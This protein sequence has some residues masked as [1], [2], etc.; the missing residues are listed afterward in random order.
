MG[1]VE[2]W[3]MFFES[4][5]SDI[6]SLIEH[7]IDVAACDC[8]QE[9]VKRR[10]K[11][12]EMVYASR[13]SA[14]DE[15]D[16]IHKKVNDI[17]ERINSY[18][19]ITVPVPKECEIVKEV[20]NIKHI[21]SNQDESENQLGDSLR[22]MESMALSIEI[23]KETMIGRNVK[24]LQKHKSKP[25]SSMAKKLVRRWREVADEWMKSAG[26]VAV[27]TMA[28]AVEQIHNHRIE[29]PFKLDD[30]QYSKQETKSGAQNHIVINHRRRRVVSQKQNLHQKLD[31]NK[32]SSLPLP[33]SHKSNSP[34]LDDKS[35][36]ERI[37]GAKRR[38]QEGYRQAEKVKKQRT[39]QLIEIKDLPKQLDGSKRLAKHHHH[40]WMKN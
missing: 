17:A 15:D 8:P 18:Q 35:V 6:C 30:R 32:P 36:R 37:E 34:A 25:I 24:C 33:S 22:R 20:F 23:L 7:A 28:A 27:D 12:A 11:I 2:E 9:L 40:Q 14:E 26:E 16:G 19:T 10:D 3:R 5:E 4:A 29:Q 13:S 38:L 1:L 21:L 39:V 31:F